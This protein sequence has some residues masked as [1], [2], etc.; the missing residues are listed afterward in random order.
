MRVGV[1]FPVVVHGDDGTGQAD[2]P[3]L[4]LTISPIWSGTNVIRSKYL[5]LVVPHKKMLADNSTF[6][7][8]MQLVV[9]E[10]EPC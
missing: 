3:C 5:I 7:A 10:C 6:E 9:R 2:D 4:A 1:T 8:A